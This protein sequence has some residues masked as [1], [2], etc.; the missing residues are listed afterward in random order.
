MI[1]VAV[2]VMIIRRQLFICHFDGLFP[3]GTVPIRILHIITGQV[4]V[5]AD[6]GG[7]DADHTVPA[8]DHKAAAG[9][10]AYHKMT[11]LP[12]LRHHDAGFCFPDRF[13]D[14]CTVIQYKTQKHAGPGRESRRLLPF[15]DIHAL[16]RHVKAFFIDS[17]HTLVGQNIKPIRIKAL[18]I[19][20]ESLQQRIVFAAPD[21]ICQGNRLILPLRSAVKNDIQPGRGRILF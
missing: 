13:I 2:A 5:R 10:I 11:V 16:D 20:P 9:R 17:V 1:T 19:R 15:F 3:E 18:L 6:I 21:G 7:D 8:L 4:E 12:V 14:I